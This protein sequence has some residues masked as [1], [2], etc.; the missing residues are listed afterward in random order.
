MCYMW[1][2]SAFSEVVNYWCGVSPIPFDGAEIG[3]YFGPGAN[4]ETA[5][6]NRQAVLVAVFRDNL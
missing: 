1:I 2:I 5:H 3:H 4:Q 6:Q